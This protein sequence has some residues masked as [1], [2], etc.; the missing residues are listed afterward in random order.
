[1]ATAPKPETVKTEEEIIEMID[2]RP[3]GSSSVPWALA[4]VAVVLVLTVG[5]IVCVMLALPGKLADDTITKIEKVL[6][7]NVKIEQVISNTIGEL[8]KES[9]IVVFTAEI[10]VSE[11]RASTKKV[12]WDKLDLG[13]TVVE[14]RVPG[15]KVQYIIPTNVISKDTFR[16]DD[17]RGEVVIDIPTPI[18][19]EEIVEIQSDPSRIEVRKEIGWGRL[20]SHS[21]AFLE[22]QIRGNL[23]SL[24]IEGGKNELLLERARKNAEEAI[25][26]LFQQFMQKEKVEVPVRTYINT[27]VN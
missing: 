2:N 20:E 26:G 13:K 1:M 9:K 16:W 14:V 7:P 8:K 27:Y 23:R 15:N 25:R 3:R 18:L 4:L 17:A 24:T 11:K 21:G 12:L 5:Y 10:T 22:Q 6:R 19:D